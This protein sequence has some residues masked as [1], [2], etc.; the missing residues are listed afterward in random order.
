MPIADT[1]NRNI[2]INPRHREAA[3]IT[4]SRIEAAAYDPGLFTFD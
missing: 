3:R 1:E 4:V 2:L